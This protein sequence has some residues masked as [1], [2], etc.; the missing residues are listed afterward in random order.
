VNCLIGDRTRV[1]HRGQMSHN[2]VRRLS[3]AGA[4]WRVELGETAAAE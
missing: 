4:Q 2:K 3:M 1:S